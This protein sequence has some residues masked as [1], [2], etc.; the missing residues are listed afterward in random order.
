[1]RQRGPR[2]AQPHGQQR[3][4]VVKGLVMPLVVGALHHRI[5]WRVQKKTNN[6]PDYLHKKRIRREH[7]ALLPVGDAQGSA[8][9]SKKRW[10]WKSLWMQ[11][12]I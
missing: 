4:R 5:I 6:P 7:E 12:E 3:L 2:C 8:P 10:F 9:A 11:P 1:M